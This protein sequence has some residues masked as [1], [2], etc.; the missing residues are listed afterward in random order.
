[1][2]G[3]PFHEVVVGF[4]NNELDDQL[5]AAAVRGGSDLISQVLVATLV[6]NTVIPEEHQPAVAEVL[7]A[8]AQKIGDE[9]DY[10]IPF[11]KALFN[12]KAAGAVDEVLKGLDE[13]NPKYKNLKAIKD[14]MDELAT[15]AGETKKEEVEGKEEKG[16]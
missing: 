12:L 15:V 14:K 16:E 9:D 8:A 13:E 2:A 3:K 6:A 10:R 1:M 11:A 7:I 4:F 5:N